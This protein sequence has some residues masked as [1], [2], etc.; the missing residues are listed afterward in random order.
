[1][2]A[3]N[4]LQKS[5]TQKPV[6][7]LAGIL[8]FAVLVRLYFYTGHVFSDDSYYTQLAY[9]LL[10]GSYSLNYLGNPNEYLGYP[11]FVIRILHVGLTALS[12]GIF[13]VNETASVIVPFLF[14]LGG[15]VLIYNLAK[16]FTENEAARLTAAFLLALF[17]TDVIFAT[18]N[19]ADLQ[20]AFVLNLGLYFLIKGYKKERIILS[21]LGG[22]F[23][24]L[25]FFIK[26]YV[27]YVII[28][29]GVLFL[30]QLVKHRKLNYHLVAA[31]AAV[32]LLIIGE[33]IAYYLITDD[34][35][36]RFTML[37][38]NYNYCYYDFF[39]YTMLGAEFTLGQYYLALAKNV[40]LY[41]VKY[42][43]LRRYYLFLPI[44]AI[45]Q[46]VISLRKRENSLLIYWFAGFAFLFIFFT[47]SFSGYKPLELRRSWY[48]LTALPPV[49]ILSAVMFQSIKTNWKYLLLVLYAVGSIVMCNEYKIFFNAENLEQ[50]KSY[51]TENE[52]RVIYTD[53]HTKYGI[54]L[55]RGY[56][57]SKNTN[58]VLGENYH[59][60]EIEKEDLLIYNDKI[61]GELKLQGHAFPDFNR[62]LGG[63]YKRVNSFGNYQIYQPK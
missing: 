63:D 3:I 20:T 36:F 4:D 53:H 28:L 49:I 58:A 59:L 35:L 46:S 2:K 47:T 11:V 22:I 12:F 40:F 19:F 18:I 17:P 33:G 51:L 6:Y 13:G 10:N 7:V 9:Q 45:V 42:F 25:S 43:F 23:L 60:D 16:L 62:T 38:A 54:D 27:Y 44:A 55:V 14:S 37:K 39:P 61:V 34:F 30:Y 41:N 52:D 8:L 29:S 31:M 50:F 48:I 26:A 21:V 24:G 57:H 32:G 5:F 56:G 15:I 1:M